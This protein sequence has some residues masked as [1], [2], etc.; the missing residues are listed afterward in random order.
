MTVALLG[1]PLDAARR[2]GG[3]ARGG[4]WTPPRRTLQQQRPECSRCAGDG[5]PRGLPRGIDGQAWSEFLGQPIFAHGG[6]TLFPPPTG[7]RFEGRFR[8]RAA[9]GVAH[10]LAT[11][12]DLRAEGSVVPTGFEANITAVVGGEKAQGAVIAGVNGDSHFALLGFGPHRAAHDQRIV[13]HAPLNKEVIFM[14]RQHGAYGAKPSNV[15]GQG[16]DA[17]AACGRS[18]AP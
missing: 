8:P 7:N 14:W 15:Q 12:T 10:E 9:Q 13:H 1:A 18:P 5:K 4:R 3:Q 11:F 16:E 2:Q 6:A 17:S